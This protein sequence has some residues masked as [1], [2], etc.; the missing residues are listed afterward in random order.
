MSWTAYYA[1]GTQLHQYPDNGS[2]NTYDDIDRDKLVKF[3]LSVFDRTFT[4]SLEE[5]RRLIY[6][7]RV[8]KT[9]GGK[10]ISIY[11]LGWQKTIKGENIQSI[12]FISP[13]EVVSAG[14]W[15]KG[16]F[17]RPNLYEFK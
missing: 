6:R 17:A 12:M 10:S 1:D 15:G 14:R 13:N 3:S 11:L 7:H 9:S 4:I 2:A 8:V 16:L 5:G